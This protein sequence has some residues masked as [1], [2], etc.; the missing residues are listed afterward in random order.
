MN[1]DKNAKK[2]GWEGRVKK[3]LRKNK[4]CSLKNLNMVT[5]NGSQTTRFHP[6]DSRLRVKYVF[7]IIF[8]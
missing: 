1:E 4:L 8:G 2:S 7:C 6:S 5:A 3:K